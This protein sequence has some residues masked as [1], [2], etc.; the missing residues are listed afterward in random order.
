MTSTSQEPRPAHPLGALL[1]VCEFCVCREHKHR[2]ILNPGMPETLAESLW[3]LCLLMDTIFE[4][5]VSEFVSYYHGTSN[6]GRCQA[7][8]HPVAGNRDMDKT[9]PLA[10]WSSHSSARREMSIK[11]K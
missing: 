11:N 3:D 6:A 5:F 2:C 4:P 1:S 9:K 10:S 7:F 8:F